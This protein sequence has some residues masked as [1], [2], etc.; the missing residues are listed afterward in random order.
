MSDPQF[1]EFPQREGKGATVRVWFKSF[2]DAF[3]WMRDQGLIGANSG[4]EVF[5]TWAEDQRKVVEKEVKGLRKKL[6]KWIGSL[7]E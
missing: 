2:N 4:K 1:F 6:A 7:R 5:D 3:N